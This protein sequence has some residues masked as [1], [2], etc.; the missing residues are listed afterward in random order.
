MPTMQQQILFDIVQDRMSTVQKSLW[1]TD[2]DL[3]ED[4]ESGIGNI[5]E[6]ESIAIDLEAECQKIT[7]VAGFDDLHS[8][9]ADSI[10]ISYRE[11]EEAFHEKLHY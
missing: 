2:N 6:G 3:M 5:R 7:K 11:L 10:I 4:I 9:G 1:K 8:I